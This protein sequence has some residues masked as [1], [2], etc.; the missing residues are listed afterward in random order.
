VL[1]SYSIILPAFNEEVCLPGTL[2]GVHAA[3]KMVA[4]SGE[5]IVVDNNSTD[6][7]AEVA[8]ANG[9]RVVF[10]PVNQISRARNAGARA[11]TAPWLI[12]LDADTFLPPG[13]LVRAL[14]NLRSGKIGGGGAMLE[15]E[16][17]IEPRYQRV[18]NL[19]T[20]LSHKMRWA[21]G[22]F[23]YCRREG[24]DAIGG[25]SE[26]VYAAEEIFFSHYYAR[27]ARRHKLGYC[28]IDSPPVITSARKLGWYSPWQIFSLFAV[29]TLCPVAVRSKR[30]CAFWYRRPVVG[31][32]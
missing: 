6:R 21:A 16:G 23:I 32:E 14:E 9:A 22:S 29:M 19:W 13:L 25:F 4:E 18:V 12:F 17:V 8:R 11:A 20:W 30:L 27:W 2:A 24:F 5:V 7:T 31:R 26:K 28:I 3:M 1:P 10:E 15:M